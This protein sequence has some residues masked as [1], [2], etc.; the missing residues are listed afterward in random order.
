MRPLT[1]LRGVEADVVGVV[2][3]GR[4]LLP[5]R[6]SRGFARVGHI[7]RSLLGAVVTCGKENR[8]T[9][10]KTHRLQKRCLAGGRGTARRYAQ[11]PR[12]PKRCCCL[13]AGRKHQGNTSLPQIMRYTAKAHSGL[14]AE[15]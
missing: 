12:R 11:L 8:E 4:E 14:D 9:K 5:S 1:R 10:I 2:R 6:E 3:T 7:W 15:S 13:A